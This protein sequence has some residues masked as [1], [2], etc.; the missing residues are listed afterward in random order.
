M[1]RREFIEWLSRPRA[2]RVELR[3]SGRLINIYAAIGAIILWFCIAMLIC[4]W[5]AGA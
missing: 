4:T 1:D 5:G 3:Y 2:T